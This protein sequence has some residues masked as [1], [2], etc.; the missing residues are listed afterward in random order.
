MTEPMPS[1]EQ[2]PIQPI[3][4]QS[5][6]NEVIELGLYETKRRS[7]GR[8][9]HISA[10]SLWNS[11]LMTDCSLEAFHPMKAEIPATKSFSS[12]SSDGHQNRQILSN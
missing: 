5:G 1:F 6:A 7:M 4:M 2:N 10:K 12:C 9:T 11:F 8:R 3:Y